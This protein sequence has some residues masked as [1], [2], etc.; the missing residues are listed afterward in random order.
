MQF[1][2]L[3]LTVPGCVSS[4]NAIPDLA[5]IETADTRNKHPNTKHA[6][7]DQNEILQTRRQ[8]KFL[9]FTHGAHQKWAIMQENPMS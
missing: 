1:C 9:G 3:Q 7:K 8:T 4:A 2:S 6:L 5:A